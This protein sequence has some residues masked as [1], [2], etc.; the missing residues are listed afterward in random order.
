MHE[1]LTENPACFDEARPEQLYPFFEILFLVPDPVPENFSSHSWKP[2]WDIPTDEIHLED[3]KVYDSGYTLET[4]CT[5]FGQWSPND[6]TAFN[7]WLRS[8]HTETYLYA[9]IENA[10]KW[11]DPFSVPE[12][13]Q[14]RWASAI[15]GLFRYW[16]KHKLS[17]RQRY[18]KER[19]EALQ[20]RGRVI[21]IEHGR[22]WKTN[23]PFTAKRRKLNRMYQILPPFYE[24]L[25]RLR[26]EHWEWSRRPKRW[27]N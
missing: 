22:R 5:S 23:M 26:G 10:R 24:S 27:F 14:K 25:R 20:Q 18:I 8:E 7:E 17:A 2:R 15:D 9:Q 1:K 16:K 12:K 4:L 21:A 19:N 3:R 11:R 6:Q 13:D